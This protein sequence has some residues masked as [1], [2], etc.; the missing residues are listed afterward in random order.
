MSHPSFE[1][2]T[3][4]FLERRVLGFIPVPSPLGCDS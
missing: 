2:P 3:F 4:S 1:I